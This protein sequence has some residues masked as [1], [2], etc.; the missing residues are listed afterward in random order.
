MNIVLRLHTQKLLRKY[1]LA[2]GVSLDELPALPSAVNLDDLAYWLSRERIRHSQS[3]KKPKTELAFVSL[4]NELLHDLC[5]ALN[6]D[7]IKR[8]EEENRSVMDKIKFG[9]LTAAGILVAACQGFDGIYTMLSIF[10]LS[11]SII[12]GFGF[13]FSFLSVIVFCGFDLIKVSNALGVR[14]N[15]SYKLLDAYLLQLQMI[16]S[17]RKKINGYCFCDLP[18]N[19]LQEQEQIVSIL[20]T[21]FL[22]LAEASSQLNRAL[23]SENM[24]IA[25]TLMSV[26]SAILFFG[27]G[28][29][30]GQS[31]A[32]F[33]LTLMGSAIPAFWPVIIFSTL[34]GLAALSLYW[35]VERPELSKLVSSWFGLDEENIQKLCDEDL[36]LKESKK[37]NHLER[38]I[39]SI[40]R[41]TGR[42]MPSEQGVFT[43]ERQF[44]EELVPQ[45]LPGIKAS[46]NNYSFLKPSDL[47][48]KKSITP[49]LF[50]D[51]SLE[52]LDKSCLCL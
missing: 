51:E 40:S 2:S 37:L 24:E 41:I 28:F 39:I 8:T 36:I 44:G 34:V 50:I 30:A 45:P 5:D 31:V 20:K 7:N 42:T 9:L 47:T 46:T 23:H 22:S 18:A 1:L 49:A 6:V 26:G 35:Y 12:F 19:V 16:K 25:K 10:E 4:Q 32:V 21:C 52:D 15:D 13:V 17:I 43:Q 48:P 33:T 38:N 29:F 3:S 11:P 27:S 14:I